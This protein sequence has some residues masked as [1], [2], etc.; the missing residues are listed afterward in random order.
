MYSILGNQNDEEDKKKIKRPSA[1]SSFQSLKTDYISLMESFY[2]KKEYIIKAEK[3]MNE[4]FSFNNIYSAVLDKKNDDNWGEFGFADRNFDCPQFYNRYFSMPTV[5]FNSGKQALSTLSYGFMSIKFLIESERLSFIT[6]KCDFQYLL[7]LKGLIGDSLVKNKEKIDEDVTSLLKSRFLSE[8][9]IVVLYKNDYWK[10][11]LTKDP[12]DFLFQIEFIFNQNLVEEKEQLFGFLTF[13]SDYKEYVSEFISLNQKNVKL[14]NRLES[15][16]LLIH[17]H[18]QNYANKDEL[19]NKIWLEGNA[20]FLKV[21]VLDV[22]PDGS[23]SFNLE[24][25]IDRTIIPETIRYLSLVNKYL[26]YQLKANLKQDFDSSFLAT[27]TSFFKFLKSNTKDQSKFPKQIEYVL[28]SKLKKKIILIQESLN[29]SYHY[30][31]KV[32]IKVKN[33]LKFNTNILIPEF[34]LQMAVNAALYRY[35]NDLQVIVQEVSTRRFLKGG[36][37]L[38][39][40][41]NSLSNSFSLA[42][43]LDNIPQELK[44]K[45]GYDTIKELK[46]FKNLSENGMSI[47]TRMRVITKWLLNKQKKPGLEENYFTFEN[48]KSSIDYMKKNADLNKNKTSKVTKNFTMVKFLERKFCCSNYYSYED[49][50]LLANSPPY[51]NKGIGISIIHSK[52]YFEF[53]FT[54][55]KFEKYFLKKLAEHVEEIIFEMNLLFVEKTK[56]IKF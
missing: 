18:H 42:M 19:I 14:I 38:M 21:M 30:I 29:K 36:T 37:E 13:S 6:K 44:I 4:F 46:K 48:F 15:C 1:Y 23:F 7:L 55:Y 9:F 33:K 39:F 12:K 50:I 35:T 32:S 22:F 16:L 26:D 54:S 8:E 11:N 3:E 51:D 40:I 34:F 52:D 56:K 43:S 53:L 27:I 20:Y 41:N 10:V 17:L 28:N 25:G 31:N 2:D 45:L 49:G 24:K 47:E 5:K